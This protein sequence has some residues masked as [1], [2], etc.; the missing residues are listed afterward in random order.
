MEK[1]YDL[2]LLNPD[3]KEHIGLKGYSLEF[4]LEDGEDGNNSGDILHIKM[5]GPF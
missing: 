2:N 4:I 1:H 5:F 3:E